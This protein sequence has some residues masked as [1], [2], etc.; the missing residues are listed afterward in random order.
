MITIIQTSLSKNSN[1]SKVCSKALEILKR[2]GIDSKLVDLRDIEFELCDG[3]KIEEYSKDMQ[4]LAKKLENSKGY[5]LAYPVYNYS[6]SGVCKNF[7]DIFS[8]CMDSKFVGIIN[9]SGGIRS[10]NEGVSEVMKSLGMHNNVTT[11]QPIVHT[12]KG[13]FEGDE[14]KEEKVLEKL[15]LMIDNLLDKISYD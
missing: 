14:I 6:I 12:W 5:I 11:V 13:D 15:N 1:T 4:E 3:R 10:A 2:K 9:N 8:Y 7:I